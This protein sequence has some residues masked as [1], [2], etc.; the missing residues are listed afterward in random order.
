MTL[1]RDRVNR[2]TGLV[3]L[4]IDGSRLVKGD[5]VSVMPVKEELIDCVVRD[6]MAMREPRNGNAVGD[7]VFD[8]DSI[9]SFN[10]CDANEI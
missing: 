9:I 8:A 10:V 1:K 3:H 4:P 7:A 2:F 6:A 5:V